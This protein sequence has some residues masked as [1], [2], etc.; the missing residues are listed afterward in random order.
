MTNEQKKEYLAKY[1]LQQAK[2]RRL[3]ELIEENGGCMTTGFVGTPYI[4]HV[5]TK[6][7][8]NELAYELLLRKEYP[9]WLYI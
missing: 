1:R 4:L 6:Y 9:S 7:G 2:I 5:L 8:Y 3:C